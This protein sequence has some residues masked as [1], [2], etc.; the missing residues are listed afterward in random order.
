MFAASHNTP[1]PAKR[2]GT[3]PNRLP[4]PIMYQLLSRVSKK[5]PYFKSGAN[6]AFLQRLSHQGGNHKTCRFALRT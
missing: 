3:Q 1:R 4:G 5:P 6:I 2:N